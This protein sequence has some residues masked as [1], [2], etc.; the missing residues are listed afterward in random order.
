M[1]MSSLYAVGKCERYCSTSEEKLRRAENLL[2][3]YE[4]DGPLVAEFQRSAADKR[5][6]KQDEL[7]TYAA[8][9][10]TLDYLFSR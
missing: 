7:R 3:Y 6:Q 5:Q 1:K 8:M 9:R 2:H 4:R 10:K